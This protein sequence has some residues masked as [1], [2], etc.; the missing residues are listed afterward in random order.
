MSVCRILGL[1]SAIVLVTGCQSWQFD[2]IEKLP[3]TASLPDTSQS[4]VVETWYYDGITGTKV[5]DLRSAEKF[6][7]NPDEIVELNSLQS[8]TD[9][10]D[11]YGSLTRGYIQP[12]TDGSYRFFV[13]GDDETQLWL[14]TSEDPTQADMIASVTGWSS[15][16]DYN[17]YSSQTSASIP[18]DSGEKYYF[19]IRHQEGVGGDHFGVAWEGP[20]ISQQVIDGAYLYS[21]AQ[22]TE[23]QDLSTEEAYSLGYRVGF[24]DGSEGL[25]FNQLYPP[26]DTDGDG[27]YDNWEVVHGLDP[28]DPADASSDPDGDLLSAADEFLLGT[29]ENNPDSDNDGIPDGAEYAYG[30][31]PLDPADANED[32][33]ADGYTNLEEH[34]AGTALNDPNDTPAPEAPTYIAGF[35]AQFFE[36]TSFDRFVLVETHET[37]NFDWGRGQPHPELPDDEFSIRWNG[38][39]TAPHETGSNEYRFSVSTNDGVRLYANGELVIDDWTGHPTTTFTYDRSL[40]AGE[41]LNL[42]IEYYEGVGSSVAQY[43]A[44]N[45]TTG[46]TLSTAATVTTPDSST[47]NDLDT[48]SDGI[49]DTWELRHGLSPWVSDADVINNA[50]GVTNLQAYQSSV[51]PYTLETVQ[52]DGDTGETG[53]TP[54]EPAPT[55]PAP[56]EDGSVT[57]TWT[58]PLTRMD[59][60][61]IALSEIDFYTINY[62]QDVNSLQQS[63]DVGGEQTSYT[64]EGLTSGTW[65]FTIK[66]VDTDGLSS[67]PSSPVSTQIN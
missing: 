8:P 52:T 63:Q 17:K 49:P 36:G 67:P 62:G 40:R 21:Y 46:E 55:E 26:L 31:D 12:P 10:A 51:D 45:L 48:D 29:S 27:I 42:T 5:E 59:G 66:V 22:V 61:S 11:N 58:A 44:T 34:L 4:G 20:G 23:P 37:V 13:A 41:R 57:L 64:F 18:L 38:I 65:Y 14:S 32:L 53:T 7:D 2:N 1:G 28:N 56:A 25:A 24:L 47:R 33:D 16:G 6:P 15:P 30:L 60:S 39:F 50:E 3:P 35:G 54:T 9:R 43:S 19:E